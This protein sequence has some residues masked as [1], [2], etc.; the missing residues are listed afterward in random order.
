MASCAS[1]FS[2]FSLARTKQE[3]KEQVG[4]LKSY[5][6]LEAQLAITE[7]A[8]REAMVLAS[9]NAEKLETQEALANSLEESCKSAQEEKLSIKGMLGEVSRQFESSKVLWGEIE[10]LSRIKDSVELKIHQFRDKFGAMETVS[11]RVERLE[12]E[13]GELT[14]R[15]NSLEA[16]YRTLEEE[17]ESM[18][19][20]LGKSRADFES[21][22]VLLK[23]S[24]DEAKNFLSSSRV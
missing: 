4:E 21:V 3:L 5:L 14:Q 17:N 24:R 9:E 22:F 10:D 13:R 8:R 1:N 12:K 11:L 23:K 19:T 20:S 2:A 15:L 7:Q 6:E 18:E 16:K